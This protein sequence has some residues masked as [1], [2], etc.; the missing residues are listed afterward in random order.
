MKQSLVSHLFAII[1]LIFLTNCKKTNNSVGGPPF[2]NNDSVQF[3]T[4]PKSVYNGPG[5]LSFSSIVIDDKNNK[6]LTTPSSGIFRFDG[7]NWTVYNSTNMPIDITKY[8]NFGLLGDSKGTIYS[9]LE[10]F[11]GEDV[12]SPAFIL[13]KDGA[14]QSF[15]PPFL[16]YGV[17]IDKWTDLVYFQSGGDSIYKYN[18]SGSYSDLTSYT[19][20]YLGG[21]YATI[22][23]SVSHDS[24]LVFFDQNFPGA[25]T[26]SAHC[27]FLVRNG[28]GNIT[29][30]NYPDATNQI[31][32]NGI[33]GSDG[34]SVYMTGGPS[35]YTFYTPTDNYDSLYMFDGTKW[36]NIPM[37]FP[38]GYQ[39]VD[40]MK[41]SNDGV[42]WISYGWS[43]MVSYENRQFRFHDLSDS[44]PYSHI[45]DFAFD[46]DNVKWLA[47]WEG[48]VRYVVQ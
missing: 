27:G 17:A 5:Q 48:L 10:P 25:I 22:S 24:V 19:G 23:F 29:V 33:F 37:I 15:S 4:P 26:D 11:S 8:E 31:L 21:D 45:S 3:F 36:N 46:S 6:W 42:L 44:K 41:Y 16:V 1:V 9:Y 40:F 47:C 14:W 43:G 35:F 20:I 38:T 2:V 18:G 13:F 30:H 12:T 32:L 39:W 7:Q 34:K 28:N